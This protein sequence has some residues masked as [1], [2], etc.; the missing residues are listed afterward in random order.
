MNKSLESFRNIHAGE[1]MLFVGLG[2]N[3]ELT[4]PEWFDFPS[5]SVN[6]IH[7]REGFTPDFYTCV[8][9]RNWVEY[10][11]KI[12]AQYAAIPKF[13]PEKMARWQGENFYIFHGELSRDWLPSDKR[14]WQDDISRE[15][16]YQNITHVALKLLYHMG[17]KTILIIGMEHK[18][19]ESHVHFWGNDT[20]GISEDH[21]RLWFE[22]YRQIVAG[23]RSKG[24]T[25]LNLSP[26]TYV[27]SDIIP[28]DD[29]HNWYT[30]VT[31]TKAAV[32]V[33]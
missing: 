14:M 11:T 2:K 9:K 19:K 22:G 26:D 32:Y 3:L 13:I 7:K 31:Q 4:P 10:G 15:I 12:A 8:D 28:R 20:P 30:P 29:W 17:A 23:L 18:P 25:V 24:V 27:P 1:T 33:E 5:I 6:S 16:T 21:V